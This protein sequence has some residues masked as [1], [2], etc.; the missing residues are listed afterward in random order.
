MLE[1]LKTNPS[2]VCV[3]AYIYIC[4]KYILWEDKQEVNTIGNFQG[5][6]WPI[7]ERVKSLNIILYLLNFEP[8][9]Y[10]GEKRKTWNLR[11]Q[12]NW[13]GASF[14]LLAFLRTWLRIGVKCRQVK[15]ARK[16]KWEDMAGAWG[17]SSQESG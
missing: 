12:V 16:G 7:R 6:N 11:K 9:E 15:G 4:I 3:C 14:Q 8:L 10:T 5:R 2:S 1:S 13:F 17:S